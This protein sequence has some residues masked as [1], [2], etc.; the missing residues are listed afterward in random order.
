[1]LLKNT[2]KLF[3]ISILIYTQ[4]Q[5]VSYA[6]EKPYIEY[7]RIFTIS[8]PPF[9]TT[10][11]SSFSKRFLGFDKKNIINSFNF[12]GVKM[13]EKKLKDY[14]LLIKSYDNTN[15]PKSSQSHAIDVYILDKNNICIGYSLT[16]ILCSEVENKG[17]EP[18]INQIK[19]LTKENNF[20]SKIGIP[21]LK[22]RIT[23]VKQH[24]NNFIEMYSFFNFEENECIG[25]EGFF[26]K[27]L[28]LILSKYIKDTYYGVD[29]KD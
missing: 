25:L 16:D 11:V 28:K 12:P 17:K 18:I 29:V 10:K 14:T 21:E 19:T 13:S 24:S 15:V 23:Y 4:L 9:I 22:N 3:F 2:V 6:E 8:N 7:D 27:E 1:M 5:N 20:Y 26:P